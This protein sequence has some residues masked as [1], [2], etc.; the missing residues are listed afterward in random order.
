MPGLA[1]EKIR[2]ITLN[3]G[4]YY[5]NVKWFHKN[6]TTCEP[7]T[8]IKA[9]MPHLVNEFLQTNRQSLERHAS[10]LYM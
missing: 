3:N 8:K 2:L 4:I 1:I 7:L 5:L 10:S 6:E 9:L